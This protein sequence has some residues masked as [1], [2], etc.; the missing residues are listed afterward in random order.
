[1]F[2]LQSL[3]DLSSQSGMEPL[4]LPYLPVSEGEVLTPG[5]PGK[6]PGFSTTGGPK[7]VLSQAPKAQLVCLLQ[8]TP[9]PCAESQQRTLFAK[10]HR[11]QG[12]PLTWPPCSKLWNALYLPLSLSPSLSHFSPYS[13]YHFLTY[14]ISFL[15]IASLPKETTGS[16]R[17]RNL[18]SFV[19]CLTSSTQ[20][21]ARHV[22][23]IW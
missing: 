22:A 21:S 20:D 5:P 11:H 12:F 6:S 9:G 19:Q 17:A 1:M 2:W 15:F 13:T 14:Y 8:P 16:M 18:I 4:T 23:G 3:W 7:W 10:H